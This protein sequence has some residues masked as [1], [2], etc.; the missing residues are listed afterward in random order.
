MIIFWMETWRKLK[1]I[2]TL[3]VGNAIVV[4][5]LQLYINNRL[6][7]G[8]TCALKESRESSESTCCV[9]WNN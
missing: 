2:T 9:N 5:H 6:L 4:P 3:Y 8:C 7:Y 1:R